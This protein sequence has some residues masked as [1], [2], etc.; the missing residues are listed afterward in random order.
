MPTASPVGTAGYLVHLTGTILDWPRTLLVSFDT[1]Q[2]ARVAQTGTQTQKEKVLLLL[3]L[4]CCLS[5]SSVGLFSW[6]ADIIYHMHLWPLTLHQSF[7]PVC[8]ENPSFQELRTQLIAH[9]GSVQHLPL[10]EDMKVNSADG[11]GKFSPEE[12]QKGMGSEK[13]ERWE[14]LEQNRITVKHG[15]VCNFSI[16]FHT[17]VWGQSSTTL[18][19]NCS[20]LFADVIQLPGWRADTYIIIYTLITSLVDWDR[21][22]F[23]RQK[24]RLASRLKPVSYYVWQIPHDQHCRIV[25]YLHHCLLQT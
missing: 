22:D 12:I 20:F 14:W 10:P 24:H 2:Q 5:V 3:L 11:F 23:C 16:V 6:L 1:C 15:G 13:V 8:Y 25:N 4:G 18:M 21:C 19:G 17:H 9:N 7:V